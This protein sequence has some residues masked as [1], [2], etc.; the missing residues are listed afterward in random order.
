MPGIKNSML[1]LNVNSSEKMSKK[2]DLF[3]L[4]FI[5]INENLKIVLSPN[6]QEEFYTLANISL[7]TLVATGQNQEVNFYKLF[8]PI[9]INNSKGRI[10]YIHGLEVGPCFA[11]SEE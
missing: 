2:H 6:A 11:E 4:E 10:T 9:E 5:W 1:K 7:D 3:S 8:I